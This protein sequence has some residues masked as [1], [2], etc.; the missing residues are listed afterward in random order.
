MINLIVKLLLGFLF[1]PLIV[2]ATSQQHKL[3]KE[4]VE[5]YTWKKSSPETIYNYEFKETIFFPQP[6]SNSTEKISKYWIDL[7]H[8]LYMETD[9][10]EY[11]M[12]DKSI[13][14]IDHY[15]HTLNAY[16][17]PKNKQEQ[18]PLSSLEI[19]ISQMDKYNVEIDK[20]KNYLYVFEVKREDEMTKEYLYTEL[21]KICIN[22]K[23]KELVY[24]EVQTN[25]TDSEFSGKRIELLKFSKTNIN[26]LPV[27]INYVFQDKTPE[28]LS[29]YENK[30]FK[31]LNALNQ[32]L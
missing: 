22:P 24:T 9:L 28:L 5:K 3:L 23:S 19:L 7:K 15:E 4:V 18:D 31:L 8:H 1:F 26:L 16:S 10:F 6:N 2:G 11:I 25:Q 13:Y 29:F 14:I 21:I 27:P 20:N 12:T 30:S 17:S 32:K